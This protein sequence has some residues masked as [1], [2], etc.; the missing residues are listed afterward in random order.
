[1][2]INRPLLAV[3]LLF[4]TTVSASNMGSIAFIHDN[5]GI[6]GTDRHYSAGMFFEFYSASSR[7][8]AI[9]APPL[10][11]YPAK[12]LLNEGYQQGWSF[13]LSQ[14]IWTP[15]DIELEQPQPNERPY[16]GTLLLGGQ[17]YQYTNNFSE[18]FQLEAGV[19]GPAALTKYGQ[20]WLHDLIGSDSP[21]GWDYQVNNRG[22]FQLGYERQHALQTH[23][24]L[25]GLDS[26]FSL[27][28]RA[29][30]GNFRSEIASGGVWRLGSPLGQSFGAVSFVPGRHVESGL[31]AT[32][33]QGWFIYSGIEM[34]YRLYDVTLSSDRPEPIYPVTLQRPQASMITGATYYQ[35]RWGASLSFI[36]TTKTFSEDRHTFS[37]YGSLNMFW[38]V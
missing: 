32:S 26:E 29:Q 5:D 11:Q 13:R 10:I 34:R 18:K 33:R 24:Y 19:V 3:A 37:H 38:R 25:N 9:D 28:G 14:S 30:M 35:P 27:Q 7:Y 1:M 36:T 2:N 8:L 17:I 12:W 31:F 20:R 23:S 4:S 6:A 15:S 21:N 22:L 16:A